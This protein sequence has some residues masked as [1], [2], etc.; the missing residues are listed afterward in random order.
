MSFDNVIPRRPNDLVRI[1]GWHNNFSGD[2]PDNL[3]GSSWGVEMYY[4][5]WVTPWLELSPDVQYLF[6]PGFE[7]GDETLILGLRARVLF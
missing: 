1:A 6:N 3:S 5:F 7:A 2:V 4:N